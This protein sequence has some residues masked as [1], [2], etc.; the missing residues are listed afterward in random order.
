[1]PSTM[2]AISYYHTF[3]RR[4]AASQ[5]GWPARLTLEFDWHG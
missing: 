1:M 2:L 5:A 3:K 4:K